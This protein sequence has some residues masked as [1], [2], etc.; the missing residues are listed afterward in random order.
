MIFH[1]TLDISTVGECSR[2]D[3]HRDY[4]NPAQSEMGS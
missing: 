1:K 2:K 4:A 3:V